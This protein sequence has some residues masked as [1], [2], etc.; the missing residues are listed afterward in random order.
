MTSLYQ[1]AWISPAQNYLILHKYH[2]HCILFFKFIIS[3]AFWVLYELSLLSSL[4]NNRKEKWIKGLECL[5]LPAHFNSCGFYRSHK[6]W[7]W[8]IC[9]IK[10]NDFRPMGG[11]LSSM[12]LLIKASLSE[13]CSLISERQG[14]DGKASL[15]GQK[16]NH[17][18]KFSS[19]RSFKGKGL[20]PPGAPEK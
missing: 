10:Q 6:F 2:T 19:T 1:V 11:S 5:C 12:H 13:C 9:A 8:E 7:Q 4:L 15:S 20:L 16:A 14:N 3:F 17:Y 18:G